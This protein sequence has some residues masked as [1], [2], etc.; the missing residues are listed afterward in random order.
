MNNKLINY[1]K[2]IVEFYALQNKVK[3]KKINLSEADPLSRKRIKMKLI[4]NTAFTPRAWVL[5]IFHV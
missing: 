1:K 4:R 2:K 5:D 3:K